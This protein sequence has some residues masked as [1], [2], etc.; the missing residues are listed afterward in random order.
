VITA[1]TTL[2]TV[3]LDRVLLLVPG[4]YAACGLQPPANSRP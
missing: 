2:L 1:N 4:P 3:N